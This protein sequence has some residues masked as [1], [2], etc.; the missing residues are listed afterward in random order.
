MKLDTATRGLFAH[1]GRG[2]LAL[3]VFA[4]AAAAQPGE[5]GP[6]PGL[7]VAIASAQQPGLAGAQST[8]DSIRQQLGD[9]EGRYL[10]PE[11]LNAGFS[12]ETR[13]ND[14]RVAYELKQYDR[15]SFMFLDVIS[16]ADA[17]FAGWR[18]AH[19]FLAESLA[20]QRNFIGAR[21]YLRAIVE[22]GSGPYYK[23]ALGRLLE[24]AY[25]TDNYEGLEDIYRKLDSTASQA[26]ALAYLRGRTLFEQERYAQARA[27]FERAAADEEFAY[28][29]RYFAA[30][31]LVSEGKLDEA[32]AIF[33]Q[34]TQ[35]I[36]IDEGDQ[37]IY[38]LA[39]LSRG[40]LAYE[41]GKYEEAIDLYN[42]LPRTDPNFISAMFESAWANVQ[43]EKF[44][45]A[46]RVIDILVQ[47]EPDP[48]MYTRAVL[49]KA[50]LAL[51]V[52]DYSTAI[53]AY[54]DVLERYDPVKEQLD[55]FA[56]QH[57][58][59]RAFF[60]GLVRDD[61][62]LEVPKGL[63]TIR[64]DFRAQPPEVWLNDDEQLGKTRQLVLDVGVAR[65]NLLSAYEDLRQIEARLESG[66]RVKSFPRLAEGMSLVVG[67]ES[68]LIGVQRLLVDR[69]AA[70]VGP[71]LQGA[72]AQ[73]WSELSA[74]LDLLG[75]RYADIPTNADELRAREKRASRDFQRLRARLNEIGAAIDELRA[76]TVAID[77]YMQTQQVPLSEEEQQRVTELRAEIRQTIT[78]LEQ[79]RQ[80]L[81][82][83]ID[84]A[85]ETVAAGDV[86]GEGERGLR[87]L[88]LEK[89]A[90]AS[91]FLHQR[92]GG[93][94]DPEGALPVVE[95]LRGQVPPLQARIQ[96]Y[97]DKM[98]GVVEQKASEV[99]KT[100]AG[101]RKMLGEQKRDLDEI[102]V[103]SKA[104]AGDIAY[105]TFS[106]RR[107]QFNGIVLRADVG[108]IDVLFQRKEDATNKINDLFQKR[109]D[110]LRALQEA[111]EEVR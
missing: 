12:L 51:R 53:G 11:L 108:K 63:P 2:V 30:V 67:L 64:T 93:A 35:R 98:D 62:S 18:A 13:Y 31:T 99:R 69:Q 102:A 16:K 57:G 25:E 48:E 73:R 42:R 105:K 10:E 36:P 20:E 54:E 86:I 3:S 87:A 80:Q 59:L 76:E 97:Y 66:A 55:Q 100:I 19:Y 101:L 47:S 106:A 58:D 81:R 77:T 72:D 22:M 37:R 41:Q 83:A 56:A 71:S 89:L 17:S 94:R 29:G 21:N 39:Y 1:L 9:I 4:L 110:E 82:N 65:E 109:T 68:E 43:L 28:K 32:A 23:E 26:P 46:G 79:E 7:G 95:R 50:D 8:L 90:E 14:A 85:R 96:A 24:I 88:Y 92:Q 70:I 38:Y 27:D 33:E 104:V 61:L 15:A 45:Q 34:L 84:V 107:E 40:R 74:E 103:G 75:K 49:L 52:E 60:R 6:V 44:E 78:E 5:R 91:D 111:F